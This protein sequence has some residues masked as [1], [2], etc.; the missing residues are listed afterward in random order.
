ML[1]APGGRLE[2]CETNRKE[3]GAGRSRKS[4]E[5]A[6]LLMESVAKRR[7]A[8]GQDCYHVRRLGLDDPVSL[9]SSH[10][11]DIC[12]KC[13]EADEANPVLSV[14]SEE[15]QHRSHGT[16]LVSTRA[17]SDW[18]A[19]KQD[20]ALEL[21]TRRGPFWEAVEELRHRRGIQAVTGL[22]KGGRIFP[23]VPLPPDAGAAALSPDYVVS[24]TY[25]T[26]DE[27][28]RWVDDLISIILKSVPERFRPRYASHSLSDWFGFIAACV[29]YDPP[30]DRLREFA[31]MGGPWGAGLQRYAGDE[32]PKSSSY[33]M[34]VAPIRRLLDPAETRQI[35]AEHWTM[36]LEKLD[37][38]HLQP[39]GLSLG[40]LLADIHEQFPE[41][42]QTKRQKMDE[43]KRGHFIEVDE[44]T[45]EEDVR[46][47][48]RALAGAHTT[49]PAAA[50]PKREKLLCVEAAVLHDWH[51][52][53]YEQLAE[54]YEWKD[55]TLA[56]KYVKD[57]RAILGE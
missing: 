36:L 53:T 38:K 23:F 21:F 54:R 52:W 28:E 11:G 47:A 14:P 35:E 10:K 8:N 31:D 30:A 15:R 4:T 9:R 48:F 16:R 32:K 12:E 24:E 5:P 39:L 40:D 18:R 19:L 49:R 26:G 1:R 44:Y 6:P 29:L 45:T 22:P 34:E 55:S 37:E 20:L 3:S 43:L 46:K 50:R 27:Y 13:K 25:L 42:R 2:C 51:G 17:A 33:S 56:S 7:C 57:G 41:I